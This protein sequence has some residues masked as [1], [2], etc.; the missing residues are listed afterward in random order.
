MELKENILSSFIAFEQ[1]VDV[2]KPLHQKRAEALKMFDQ[3]G[4][5]TKK[6]EAWK[7]TSLESLKDQLQSASKA[8]E[9][10]DYKKCQ[11]FSARWTPTSS[12]LS[13]ENTVHFCLRPRMMGLTFA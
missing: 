2:N 3:Q 4:F 1:N 7:Y 11:V 10:L 12:S 13:M 5:P 6:M 9:V 8:S